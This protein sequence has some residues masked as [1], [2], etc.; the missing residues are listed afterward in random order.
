MKKHLIHL[1][2]LLIAACTHVDNS[3]GMRTVDIAPSDRGVVSGV[4]VGG[5]DVVSMSDKMMRD[6]LS[7]PDLAGRATS[8]RIII[9]SS[10][11]ENKS[12]QAIDK[13]LITDRLRVQLN[14]AAKGRMLFVNREHIARVTQ[15][16]DLK[17]AGLMD[18]G[19]TGLADKLAGADFSLTGR[20]GT[21]D[22]GDASNG[23]V[24]RFTQITFEMMD[25]ETGVI[26]WSNDYTI[27]RAGQDNVVY[28]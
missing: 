27:N 9:D 5:H 2:I 23:M 26:V 13:D 19:S 16:R 28:R 10:L 4:G 12:S 21:L 17:R 15:E 7:V 11:F 8:P 18:H 25:L 3:E 14:R 24:Q 6:L 1:P 22:A 20:I